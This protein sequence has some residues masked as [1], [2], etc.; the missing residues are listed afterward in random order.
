M[1]ICDLEARAW[2]DGIHCVNAV[3]RSKPAEQI[4]A[5]ACDGISVTE[6]WMTLEPIFETPSPLREVRRS[7]RE[8]P[9]DIRDV[10]RVHGLFVRPGGNSGG[11]GDGEATTRRFAPHPTCSRPRC[12]GIVCTRSEGEKVHRP[13]PPSA[14]PP[15]GRGIMR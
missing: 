11:E 7:R 6:N 14:S 5:Q 8:C 12:T 3:F 4:F 15:E 9:V 10:E 2:A 1:T 13:F